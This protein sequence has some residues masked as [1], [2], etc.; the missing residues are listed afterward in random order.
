M[1]KGEKKDP[2]RFTTPFYDLAQIIA[3]FSIR[4]S[5]LHFLKYAQGNKSILIIGEGTGF[6]LTHLLRTIK[7]FNGLQIDILD[8]SGSM[9]KRSQNRF[10]K[11]FKTIPEQIS[12]INE[13]F[14]TFSTRKK[15]DIVI[16]HFFFDQFTHSTI[17]EIVQK[18]KAITSQKAYLL[19]ADFTSGK[20]ILFRLY[21]KILY[22][23]FHT[24]CKIEARNL[25]D[26]PGLIEKN[27]FR[28]IEA[29]SFFPY[30]KAIVYIKDDQRKK[31]GSI[32]SSSA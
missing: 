4:K 5:Q 15:Y 22:L 10:K 31:R 29:E 3:G 21:L 26:S 27:G 32:H 19:F 16:T 25:P 6:F 17:T 18:I 28:V 8:I 2:Y 13:D 24:V 30:V 12:W 14:L 20:N 9:I 1:V 7:S 23:Y 11:K